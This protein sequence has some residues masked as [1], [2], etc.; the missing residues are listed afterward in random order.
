MKTFK[1]S[2]IWF[3]GLS[4]SGK[5]TLS[6]RLHEALFN[7]GLKNIVLLDGEVVREEL[8]NHNFDIHNREQLGLA[9]ARIAQEHN[10]RGTIVLISGI[11]HKSKFRRDV[12]AMFEN[13]YEIFL[14]CDVNSCAKR[15]Y[16]GHYKK[17]QAGLMKDFIGISE[18]YEKSNSYDL[19]INTSSNGIDSCADL[20]F[21][22]VLKYLKA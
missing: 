6:T 22:N 18:P 14:D 20:I 5:T 19:K 8:G 17:A 7:F 21:Q 12:R 1:I 11:N 9:K 15:D 10:S 16:K 13:Y 2:T 3:T 4:A